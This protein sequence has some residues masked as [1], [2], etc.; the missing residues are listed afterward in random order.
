MPTPM[1]RRARDELH[2]VKSEYV[3]WDEAEITE[4]TIEQKV[5]LVSVVVSFRDGRTLGL[6]YWE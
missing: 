5:S 6:W 3:D 4:Q 1:T 2:H